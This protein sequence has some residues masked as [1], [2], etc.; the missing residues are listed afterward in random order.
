[1]QN[2][3]GE[4]IIT[5]LDDRFYDLEDLNGEVWK[6][7]EGYE[8]HYKV[9]N[10]GRIKSVARYIKRIKFSNFKCYEKIKKPRAN[11]GGYLYLSLEFEGKSSWFTLHTLV[12]KHFIGEKQKGLFVNHINHN[13]LDNRI[14]NLEYVTHQENIDAFWKSGI[15]RA[16]CNKKLNPIDVFKIKELKREGKSYRELATMFNVHQRTLQYICSG[17]RWKH[18]KDDNQIAPQTES[19]DTVEETDPAAREEQLEMF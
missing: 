1:M 5:Y 9:S 8:G 18:L 17:Q 11:F 13:K 10:M 19:T 16:Q 6:D 12:S 15:K 14:F 3:N 4:K 7:V 2:E